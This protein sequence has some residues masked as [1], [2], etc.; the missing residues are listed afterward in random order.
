MKKIITSILFTFI[1]FLFSASYSFATLDNNM[2]DN[3]GNSMKNVVNGTGNV[4]ENTANGAKNIVKDSGNKLKNGTE[5]VENGVANITNDNKYIAQR[6][7]SNSDVT[8][9][10]ISTGTWAWII[11]GIVA[12]AVI[13]FFWYYAANI[14]NN[15]HHE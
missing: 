4:M 6:T 3:L 14:K 5:K 9:P 12:I 8:N 11:I 7:S 15:S 1:I 13:I 10:T 2:I